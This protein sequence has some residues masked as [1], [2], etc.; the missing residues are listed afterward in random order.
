[1]SLVLLLALSARAVLPLPI[2]P[3]C[4]EADR[5][6]LCPSDLREDWKFLSYVQDEYQ[7]TVREEEH[8]VGTGMWADRAWRIT[9]GRTDVVI[10]VLDSGIQWESGDL[11]RKHYLNTAELPP[12]QVGGITSETYDV[13]GDGVVNIDDYADDPRVD[14]AAG[15]DLADDMLDPSDLIATF[16]DGS[17]DDGNGFVDDISGWD[18]FNG[19]ND[20]Y[21]DTRFGH[22]TGEAR[23]SAA[24]G[25]DGGDIGSCPNCM[26]LNLRVG[27]SFV[28]DGQAF[29]QAALYAVDS[30]AMVVQEALGVL[31]NSEHV[32]DSIEY[33]WD[34]GVTVIASAA[35]ETAYHHNYP[36]T[37]HH[38]VYVHA[39]R[40]DAEDREDSVTFQSYSNCTNHGAR[41]VLSVPSTHCSSGAT[42]YAAGVAGLMHSAARDAGVTLTSNEAYQL[43]AMTADDIDWPDPPDDI[44]ATGPGWDR[45]SGYGKLNA[46]RIVDSI[47]R[48][49]I[50]PEADLYGPRW[51]EVM[52]PAVT[53]TLDVHGLVRADR[54]AVAS[55][56]LD[57]STGLDVSEGPFTELARGTGPMDG[58]LA[59]LHLDAL[60]LDPAARIAPY[61][62]GASQVERETAVNQYT[63]TLRLRVT[64]ADGLQGEMRKSFYVEHDPD[65]MDGFP[66]W[67]ADSLDGAVN[68]AD[69][70]GDGV[71]DIVAVTGGGRVLALHGDGSA[72]AGW[73]VDTALLEEVDPTSSGNHLDAPAW[74]TVDADARAGAIAS[75]AVADLDG[76]GDPEVVVAT[77]RGEV[78]AWH[79]DGT[80]V[81]GFP[82][83]Q[84]PV[85]WTDPDHV[86]DEAFASTPALADLDGDGAA[87]IVVGGGDQHVY[88][89]HGDGSPVA[90]FPA[91]A[92]STEDVGARIVSSPALGDLDGDGLPEI[93]IG[94]NEVLGD[95]DEGRLYVLR[96]DGTPLPGWPVTISGLH[97]DLLPY[98][99]RGYA[100]SPSL[101]DL[102]GD[103]TPEVVG[104]AISSELYAWRADGTP[105]LTMDRTI[106]GYGSGT[107][108]AD[109]AVFPLISSSSL[110]D[111]DG[112]GTLDV[113]TPG[114]GYGYLEGMLDDG[115]LHR[116]DHALLANSGD[117]GEL[118][119]GFPQAMEDLQ[120]FLNPVLADVNGDHE[121]EALAG[122]GGFVLHAWDADGVEPEGWPKFTG[123]WLIASPAVGDVDGDG[124]LDVVVGTRNGWL[125]AWTTTSPAGADVAW[126]SFGHDAA[127][128][129]NHATDLGGLY[130]HGYELPDTGDDDQDGCGCSS[131]P[132]AA[133]WLLIAPLALAWRRRA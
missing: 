120:F 28:A 15:Q 93:V 9:T 46:W 97:M 34:H 32:R 66:L 67:V 127:N 72:L 7:D 53:P 128:T 4:G 94:T 61:A 105:Y 108:V 16:S 117:D 99:G 42:E 102:D 14:P 85:P 58:L 36:G 107:N 64:D 92:S 101:G 5:P 132:A 20:P 103:G 23:G 82:V 2:F 3:E 63:V 60:D 54:S 129:S 47:A 112:D 13:N 113:V 91:R 78:F 114:T 75:P 44:Y 80:T 50:P 87:E 81:D 121:L 88:A 133:W 49:A 123:Q 24:E 118:L 43:M 29:A 110:G 90:G 41:L 65:R 17:D 6:D 84:D 96:G 86:W 40:Y 109:V 68:L 31:T 79:H 100:G 52:D 70:D 122:S 18:F 83:F 69:L 73:P 74:D 106:G 95:E 98:V 57:V 89:W 26:V 111:M 25:G 27:D 21:D 10:A 76:D 62:S 130:N 37:N 30:G 35:D 71:L 19:D 125:Y 22:G 115:H 119:D 11:V 56:V 126:A 12:P 77:L 8:D 116:F 38:T 124:W 45:I 131:G 55:W 59:T 104:N 48:G 1:M 39:V 51:F 33:A